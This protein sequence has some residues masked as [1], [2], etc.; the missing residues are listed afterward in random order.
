MRILLIMLWVV[1]ALP[2]MAQRKVTLKQA[3]DLKGAVKDGNRFDRLIGNVIL[4]HNKTTI[5]CDSAHL[6][7]STNSVEAFGRVRITEGDSV[8]ITAAKLEYDGNVQRAKLRRNVVFTKL[9]TATLYTDNLDYDRPVNQAYY[10]N[11]GRLVDSIN[12][13][14]SNKGYYNISNNL[15]SFKKEVVVKNPDYTMTSD[16]LQYNSRSKVI[17]FVTR[18][19]LIDKDSSTFVYEEGQY[20]TRTRASDL[21]EGIAQTTSY[22]LQGKTYALDDLR[23]IYRIRGDIVMTYKDEN[24]TIY[25][26]AADYFRNLG[27]AKIY[28]N[29]YVA[30][31]TDE[32]DTLFMRADTLVSI[33]SQDPAK[34]KL[35]AYH[36]V[37]IFKRDLQ[38]IAD[39]LEYRAIDST[40]YFYNQPV[41]WTEGNQMTADSISML[42]ERQTI[43]KIFMKDN[44]FVISRDTLINYN[45]IKGRKMTADFRNRKINQVHVEGNGES[46]YFA[47]DEKT[48]TLTGMNRII[49]S[50]M[51]IRFNNGRVSTLSFYVKP[52]AQFVP[53]H[54]LMDDD[55][56]LKGF[57]WQGDQRP[58]RV[59]VVGQQPT[60]ETTLPTEKP[61]PIKKSPRELERSPTKKKIGKRS[62]I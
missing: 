18:T 62:G 39:S 33:D 28:N 54:E 47:I 48:S 10:F 29:A 30:K 49:C 25:G 59:E 26:Q 40:I 14:T 5:Y 37:K 7:S 53:P 4:V 60:P 55:K 20:D 3:D 2:A 16:S 41:L 38:G 19:T 36:H 45:Q 21:K 22:S 42:I 27:I 23:K 1:L 24:M 56:T 15:A 13:L 31:V 57:S 12:V 8:T 9:S 6:F 43:S 44:A 11:G 52:E 51:V 50:S 61:L 35:L 46:L 34:K 17:Y 32:G 58:T